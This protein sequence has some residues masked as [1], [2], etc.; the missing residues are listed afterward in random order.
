MIGQII[1]SFEAVVIVTVSTL[2][3][4]LLIFCVVMIIDAATGAFFSRKAY[5]ETTADKA[6]PTSD[7]VDP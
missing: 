4:M 6:N 7:G 1:T 3:V 5:D 2:A